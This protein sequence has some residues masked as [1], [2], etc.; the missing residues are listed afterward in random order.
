MNDAENGG[1]PPQLEAKRRIRTLRSCSTHVTSLAICSI[2]ETLYAIVAEWVGD[3][4]ALIFE[5]IDGGG[6]HKLEIPA[7]YGEE[8]IR[9]EAFISMSVCSGPP[10][11][12]VFVCGTRNGLV[13]TL[14]IS[15]QDLNVVDFWSARIGA[16]SV[17]IKKD[18][19]VTDREL[20]FMTCDSKLYTLN[21]PAAQTARSNLEVS[22]G[23]RVINQ[24]WLTD[25]RN[26][27]LQQPG[28][29]AIATLLPST[30]DD[31]NADILLV[32][33]SQL[34]LADMS[35]Q[36]KPVPRNIPIR[37][38]PTRLLY[39]R[40]L[41]ALIVAAS[42]AGRCTILFIDP[43]TGHDISRPVDKKGMP[44]EYLSGLGER[45]ERVFRLLEW[46]YMKDGKTWYFI[47]VCTNTGRLLI[48]STE[49]EATKPLET[50]METDS[51]SENEAKVNGAQPLPPKIRHWTRYKFKCASPVYS[52][53]GFAEGLYYCSG[54]TLFCDI[55][56]LSE[57]KFETVAQYELPSP[58]LD[59]IYENG[60]IYATT[61]AH[62]LEVLELIKEPNGKSKIIHTHGDHVTR[63]ALHHRILG[64]S[65][66]SLLSFISDKS[67]SV[68]GLWPTHNTRAD[69]LDPVFEA[70]LSHSILRFR[71]GR[72]RPIW[73]PTW[74]QPSGTTVNPEIVPNFTGYPE[75][76]GLSIDGSL[77]HF[78]ILGFATWKF[79]RFL[80]NLAMQSPKICEF[81]YT[82]GT[83]ALEPEYEPKSM[84]HVDGD[85]LQRIEADDLQQLLRI[86]EESEEAA[87]LQSLFRELLRGL[88]KEMLDENT[89]LSVYIRQAYKDLDFFLRPVL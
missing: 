41:N 45:H 34:L 69:T 87:K 65:K 54:N 84:M 4:V 12:L 53:A 44:V 52:V 70:R 15:E 64:R 78:T 26:P 67:C 83:L 10:G 66:G 68:V 50:R 3:S 6:S 56:K 11:S 9:L 89:E 13:V 74:D 31:T 17:M 86:G 32:S 1:S 2:Q 24:V 72:C 85:I 21:V 27:C 76:L 79:L 73:D 35:T 22:S 75:V 58:A 29:T 48:L 43:E 28:V 20:L 82:Q 25:A 18:D 49:K 61:S 14:H 60:K 23:R 51:V 63:N 57:K 36:P 71:S 5:P 37:G 77:Y 47:V 88:H 19:T 42:V 40:S 7:I 38:T 80:V 16:T 59:L 8:R 55:L 33:G 30:T 81:T 46:S 62:S 39:S